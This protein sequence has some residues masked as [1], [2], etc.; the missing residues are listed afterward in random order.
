[1]KPGNYRVREMR[2]HVTTTI[3]VSDKQWLGQHPEITV[4]GLLDE[5]FNRLRE[6]RGEAGQIEPRW[7]REVRR[8]LAERAGAGMTTDEE[9]L[10]RIKKT[11]QERYPETPP[12]GATIARTRN[13]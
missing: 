8:A 13:G 3:R 4:S 9:M 5:A 11:A 1:M 2:A 12:E 10:A 7:V 6:D